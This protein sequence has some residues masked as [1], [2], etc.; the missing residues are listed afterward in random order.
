MSRKK[1]LSPLAKRHTHHRTLALGK[2]SLPALPLPP[3]GQSLNRSQNLRDLASI[4]VNGRETRASSVSPTCGRGQHQETFARCRV[5]GEHAKPP[6]LS[7]VPVARQLQDPSLEP[8]VK[9]LR[10]KRTHQFA[11]DQR[12]PWPRG[13]E[14]L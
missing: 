7:N 8:T 5:Q 13:F 3:N 10:Q 4:Q 12:S 2:R 1:I 9:P 11:G 6:N 14:N